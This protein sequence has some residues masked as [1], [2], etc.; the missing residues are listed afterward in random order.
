MRKIVAATFLTLDGVMQAPGGPEEDKSGG[1]AF[2]GWQAGSWEDAVGAAIDETFREGFDLLLGRR[3]YDIF[4]AHWPFVPTDPSVPG[5]DPGMAEIA[6]A[7]NRVTK[8]VATHRPE[9]LAWEN[10]EWLGPDPAAKLRDIK[11]GDGPM[12]LIQGS[13][14]LIQA[15]LAADLI[16]DLRLMIA[17]IVL[18]GGKRLFG[19]G[20]LPRTLRLVTSAT[21]PGGTI[22]AR[23]ERAG[24][25]K[26][27]SFALETPTEA[28][29]T[30]R[31]AMAAGRG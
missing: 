19:D 28:E 2:G 16:D 5:Y 24:A 12:L 27:A 30:R 15:L 9:S 21:T 29:V 6:V 20:T 8:Y 17:P 3:T 11:N 13:S 7:F 1:F 18:G 25:V 10:S 31:E 22:L 23:Y 4:A 26:T 14:V